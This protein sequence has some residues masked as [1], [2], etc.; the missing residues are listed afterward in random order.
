MSKQNP[1]DPD[2]IT[3]S[4]SNLPY[5]H[6]VGGA[7]ITVPD[8]NRNRSRALEAMDHQTDQQLEQIRQQMEL[9]AHQAKAIQE[10]RELSEMIY[11]A[12]IPFKP[13]INHI[14]HLYQKADET[15]VLSMIGPNEW[16]SGMKYDAFVYTVRLLADHTWDILK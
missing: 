3:D 6:T 9:L 10:R 1:I 4:P 8:L 12:H 2:K 5:A 16:S 7:K 15:Y 11:A 14:Y 13:E